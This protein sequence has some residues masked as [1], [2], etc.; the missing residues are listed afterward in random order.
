M[1]EKFAVGSYEGNEATYLGMKSM[2]TKNEDSDGVVL[3]P[4][5]YEGEINH[6]EIPHERMMAPNGILTENEQTILGSE[7]GTLMWIARIARPGAIY[8]ASAAA[9]T[10]PTGELIGFL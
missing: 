1:K 3:D 7:L 4:N 10:F 8:D 9:Q 5:K 2:K 6:I